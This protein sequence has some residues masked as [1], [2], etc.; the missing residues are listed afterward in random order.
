MS[1]K[2][3]EDNK[4]ASDAPR[5]VSTQT[6]RRRSL[7]AKCHTALR[8]THN[9]NF[10][11]AHKKSTT[12]CADL[13]YRISVVTFDIHFKVV[14]THLQHNCSLSFYVVVLVDEFS[15]ICAYSFH[16]GD[17]VVFVCITR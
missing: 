14:A 4:A 17:P 9:C 10:I 13:L 5:D 1:E 15:M 2:A 11:Y 3:C 7:L 16:L 6:V 8:Y 12:L